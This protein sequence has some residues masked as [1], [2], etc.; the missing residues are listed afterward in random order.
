MSLRIGVIGLSIGRVHLKHFAVQPDVKIVAVADLDPE[1]ARAIASRYR[2]RP[3]LDAEAMLDAEKLDVVAVCTPPG[4]HAPLVIRAAQRGVHVF[5]E[6]PMAP[7]L[8]ACD[9][10]IEAAERSGVTLAVG[11]KKRYAPAYAYLK[12]REEDWGRPCIATIQYQVGP[13]DKDWFWAEGEG[14]GPIIE[15]ACHVLDLL[16]FY[17]GE[18]RTVYAETDNFSAPDHPDTCSDAAATIRFQRGGFATLTIGTGGSWANPRGERTTLSYD[19]YVAEVSGPLDEP[20]V[21][22]VVGRTMPYTSD[23]AWTEP[24]GFAEEFAGFIASVRGGP[25]PCATG[26]DG[27]AAL[28]LGLAIKQAGRTGRPVHLAP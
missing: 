11:F 20:G 17:L 2:A 26:H 24:S 7:S 16:R 4:A 13:V 15:S 1:R 22:R 25:P 28:E 10:M 19:R 9:A 18:A 12:Q 8:A 3:Y 5:C 23:Q 14:G 6:K 21:L 27:R